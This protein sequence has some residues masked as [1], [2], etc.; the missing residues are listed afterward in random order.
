MA[1]IYRAI[2]SDD[3][4]DLIASG[5]GEV[6]RWL[7]ETKR[8]RVEAIPDDELR[9]ELRYDRF[10][11]D[12]VG[13]FELS[14]RRA[15]VG[16]TKALQIRLHEHR[17][18]VGQQ[19]TTSLTVLQVSGPGTGVLWVD[20]ER[21]SDDPFERVSFRAPRLVRNLIKAGNDPRVGQIRLDTEPRAIDAGTLAGLVR[22]ATRRLPL[23]VFSHD[24]AGF[25]TTMSRAKAA[26]ERL[27]GV[28][29]IYLLPPDQTDPFN[30]RVGDD[31]GVWGG[32]ARLYLPIRD[33]DGL[34]PERHRYVPGFRMVRGV[35]AAG[36]LFVELLSAT[37]PATPP[38]EEYETV[39]RALS[40]IGRAD[41]A[42]ALLDHADAELTAQQAEI[43]RLRQELE[44]RDEQVFDLH[45]EIEDLETEVNRKADALSRWFASQGS[46]SDAPASEE[47]PA[48]VTTI[49]EAIALATRLPDVIV[50][51]DA[52]RDIEK[53][54]GAINARA[55]ANAVWRGL[56]AL[57][58]YAANAE[59]IPGGFWE[60]CR[61]TASPW[62]WPPLRR[63]S[64][65][66]NPRQ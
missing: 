34:R 6:T 66:G 17:P 32:T 65:C 41:D 19:W 63:R 58:A 27:A 38:P 64:R 24:D 36:D 50:H 20:I 15:D 47:L 9:G 21:L 45:A 55:W 54:D 7:R 57:D 22:N 18:A 13:P 23:V 61:R 29:Q 8:I 16:G 26:Y 43:Q 25:T 37:V 60:W 35:H 1:L 56:R 4:P 31:L 28:A 39:R 2:W 10:D 46:E 30:H 48:E 44:R 59:V 49:S 3:G 40:G 52:P 33:A 42:E 62:S 5:A 11:S 14:T 12:A 53:L 51:N